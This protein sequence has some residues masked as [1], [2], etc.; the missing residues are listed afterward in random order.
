MILS[1]PCQ[2]PFP[3]LSVQ[4][5]LAGH[6]PDDKVIEALRGQDGGESVDLSNVGNIGSHDISED[7][8]VGVDPLGQQCSRE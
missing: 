5:E 3:A 8:R 4:Y 6:G 2:R 7:I 1:N